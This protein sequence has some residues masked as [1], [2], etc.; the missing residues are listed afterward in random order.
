MSKFKAGDKVMLVRVSHHKY[1]KTVKRLFGKVLDVISVGNDRNGDG[2]VLAGPPGE[3]GL[4]W[5][6]N[7]LRAATTDEIEAAQ[8]VKPLR[9]G[10]LVV[11]HG[12]IYVVYS[13]VPD[14][15]GAYSIASLT[16]D[17]EHN[18]VKIDE[19]TRISSIGKKVRLLKKEMEGSK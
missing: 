12:D 18:R 7:D 2:F 10:D 11:Y 14:R 17:S 6:A 19:L 8:K 4:V 13:E 3:G 9:R 5:H 1:H 16:G 15:E